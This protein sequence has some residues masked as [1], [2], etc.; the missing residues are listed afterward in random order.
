MT[1]VTGSLTVYEGTELSKS[2]LY[3]YVRAVDR[4]GNVGDWTSNPAF[5]N[6]DTI[7]P[8]TPTLSVVDNSTSVVKVLAGFTD[9]VSLRPS[10]FGKMIYTVNGGAELTETSWNNDTK[11]STIVVPSNN[12]AADVTDAI[13]VWA[14]DKAGNKSENYATTSVV[15]TPAKIVA[16]GID[17]KNGTTAV[18]DGTACSTSAL[19]V[20]STMTLIATPIPTN[21]DDKIVTW[22]SSNANVA[23]VNET[24]VVT[25]SNVGTASISAKIG[26]I[27]KTCTI[28]SQAQVS[29][30]GSGG[31]SG[32]CNCTYC[33]QNAC[34]NGTGQ[35]CTKSG[36]CWS[37]NGETVSDAVNPAKRYTCSTSGKTYASQAAC[38]ASCTPCPTG[39]DGKR[40]C[41]CS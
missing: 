36:D 21:S 38:S 2:I 11:V 33:T 32:G 28:S 17:L 6:I 15:V 8:N 10:G 30:T 7:K 40:G 16:T 19:Y 29:S 14:V 39:K 18:E 34:V 26:S 24:G 12:T 1:D 31:S 25:I 3:V 27:T 22:S 23:V 20:G 41:S 4:A 37:G 9:G 35:N 5:L 13:N